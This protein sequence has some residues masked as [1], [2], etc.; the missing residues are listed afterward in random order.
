MDMG[1]YAVFVWPAWGLSAVVLTGLVVRAALAS[2]RWKKAL[3]EA[4][5]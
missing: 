4:E 2:R 1:E 5:Q 3:D